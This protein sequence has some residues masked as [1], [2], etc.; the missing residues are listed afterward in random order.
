ML[1]STPR[2]TQRRT[3][4]TTAS[5]ISEGPKDVIRKHYGGTYINGRFTRNKVT[6]LDQLSENDKLA[7]MADLEEQRRQKAEEIRLKRQNRFAAQHAAQ[8]AQ[9]AKAEKVRQ[10]R[11][12]AA[13]ASAGFARPGQL[14]Q[15]ALRPLDSPENKMN[16]RLF[17]QEKRRHVRYRQLHEMEPGQTISSFTT[18]PPSVMQRVPLKQSHKHMH[19]HHHFNSSQDEFF[20]KAPSMLPSLVTKGNPMHRSFSATSHGRGTMVAP[21]G[22]RMSQSFSTGMIRAGDRPPS[23]SGSWRG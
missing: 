15:L 23:S 3:T 12:Q 10:R 18:S 16:K 8:T 14:P 21:V 1:V 4:T 2:T 20:Q 17:V 7:I 13:S 19:H 22:A 6:N 5:S 11:L 9:A